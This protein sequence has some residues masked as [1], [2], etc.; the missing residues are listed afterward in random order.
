MI[1]E[2][3]R[4]LVF[5]ILK[6]SGRIDPLFER[7]HYTAIGVTGHVSGFDDDIARKRKFKPL[8]RFE[9]W[10]LK[11]SIKFEQERRRQA[12]REA[13]KEV[14]GEDPETDWA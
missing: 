8:N 3:I 9:R 13:V 11:P 2:A 1:A 4:W 7:A 10:L 14:T 5:Q 6:F 12:W